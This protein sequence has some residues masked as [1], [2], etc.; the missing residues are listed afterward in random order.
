MRSSLGEEACDGGPKDFIADEPTRDNVPPRH[1]QKTLWPCFK[2]DVDY[3]LYFR[4]MEPATAVRKTSSQ[5]T[6]AGR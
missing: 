4:A 2:Q 3:S 1:K 5:K 6:N